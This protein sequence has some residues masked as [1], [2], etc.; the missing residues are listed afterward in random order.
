MEQGA[1]LSRGSSSDPSNG[2]K[3][4][5]G[6]RGLKSILNGLDDLWDQSQYADEY[7]MTQFLAKL[8]G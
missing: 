7:D 3:S 2:S 8:N 4:K 1:L 6:G 5:G